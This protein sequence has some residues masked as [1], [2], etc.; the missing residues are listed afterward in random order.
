[1]VGAR[2]PYG[3]RPERFVLAGGAGSAGI[4]RKLEALV[5]ESW[6]SEIRAAAEQTGELPGR[7]RVEVEPERDVV[8]VCPVGEVDLGTVDEVRA[9]LEEMQS[10]G[11]SRVVL[12][13]RRT[14]FLD[15]SGLRLAVEMD[16]ASRADGFAFAIVAG[17]PEVQ[18]AFEL[19]GLTSRLPFVEPHSGSNGRRW[20]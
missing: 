18:R 17:P 16:A 3:T 14:T 19:T 11:F 20:A 2:D 15:S 13:L 10:S 6:L 4:L 1:L 12:D 7:F 8:R 5:R 9:H